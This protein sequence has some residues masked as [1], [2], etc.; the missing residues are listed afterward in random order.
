MAL[1]VGSRLDHYDV[2]ALIGQGGMG[3]VYQA[4]DTNLDRQVA[5]KVLPAA[6]SSD[7][8]RLARFERE[9][10]VLASLNHPN[11]GAIYGLEKSGDTR[12]LVLELVAGPTLADRIAQ[13]RSQLMRLS[14][15]PSKSRRRWKP[16]TS[17]VSSTVTSSP[18]RSRSRMTAG[19]KSWTLGWRK[20]S[21]QPQRAIRRNLPR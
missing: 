12:A 11:I 19:S 16:R 14:R 6:F 7:P 10:K 8:D 3:Q 9:A 13:G 1:T 21:I 15:S 2:T 17:T 20:H 18:P 4:T 5:I